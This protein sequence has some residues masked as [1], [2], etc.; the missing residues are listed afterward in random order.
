VDEIWILFL[1]PLKWELILFF[2]EGKKVDQYA[3]SNVGR[4]KDFYTS[5]IVKAT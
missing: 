2:Q 3:D 1:F 5:R 4:Q